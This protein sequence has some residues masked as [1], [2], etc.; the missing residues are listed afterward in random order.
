MFYQWTICD[1]LSKRECGE[2]FMLGLLLFCRLTL[3]MDSFQMY[4]PV[5]LD[6]KKMVPSESQRECCL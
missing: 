4:R 5:M 3:H 1:N 2:Q 6:R